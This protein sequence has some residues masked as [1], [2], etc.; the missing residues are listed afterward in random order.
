MFRITTCA[1]TSTAIGTLIAIALGIAS[2]TPASADPPPPGAIELSVDGVHWAN[3]L[4]DSIFPSGLTWVPG[5]SLTG[6]VWVRTT[7]AAAS[8]LAT[9]QLDPDDPP[10]W[11][12]DLEVRTKATGQ[13]WSKKHAF[14]DCEATTEFTVK[15]GAPVKLELE[16]TFPYGDATTISGNETQARLVEIE[17]AAITLGCDGATTTKP[18]IREC[19]PAGQKHKSG[20]PDGRQG[21]GDSA[22]G[23]L[24]YRRA[25]QGMSRSGVETLRTVLASSLLATSGIWALSKVRHRRPGKFRIG[26]SDA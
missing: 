22:S 6:A 18:A 20:M 3:P 12:E 9:W 23:I 2:A 5:D 15:A 25:T 16:I 8:G 4:T 14:S 10:F 26:G 11:A 7:C 17:G 19:L 21:G 24:A 1:A 13:Q